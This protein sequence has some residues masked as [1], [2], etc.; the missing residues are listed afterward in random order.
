MADKT[1]LSVPLCKR[2]CGYEIRKLPLGRH[3][4]AIGEI[5]A[6]YDELT[7]LCFPGMELRDITESLAAFDEKMLRKCIGNVFAVVPTHVIGLVSRLSGIEAERLLNDENIGLDGIADIVLAVLEVNNVG[8]F[9]AAAGKV[10]GMMRPPQTRGSR[11][12]LP[13]A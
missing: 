9:L 2:V 13:P 3:I 6:L 12:S 8:K 1:K 7:G 4:E 10:R 11:G 5:H